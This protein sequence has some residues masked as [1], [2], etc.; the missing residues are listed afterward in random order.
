MAKLRGVNSVGA[1]ALEFLILTAARTGE[2]FGARWEEIDG[3]LWTIPGTRVKSG[4]PHEVPLSARC[5]EILTDIKAH[6]R[7]DAVFPGRTG[8]NPLAAVTFR[9]LLAKLGHADVTVHGFRSSFW[10]W[11]GAPASR[12]RSP[13]P[14]SRIRSATRSS[15]PTAVAVHC[16]SAG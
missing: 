9:W 13:K 8:H 6:S 15:V 5:L 7:G 12:V 14:H 11:C 3:D 1:R 16:S 4:R 2:V 10:D